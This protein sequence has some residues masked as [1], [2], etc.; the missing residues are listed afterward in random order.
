MPRYYFDYEDGPGEVHDDEGVDLANLEQARKEAMS[1]IYGLAKE[2][3]PAGDRRD[4]RLAIR[5]EG[6]PVLMVVS[7]SLSVERR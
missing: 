4:F 1:A 6:G 5:E 7:L 2:K 3:T